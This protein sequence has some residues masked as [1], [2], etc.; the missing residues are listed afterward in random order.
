[1]WWREDGTLTVK[2]AGAALNGTIC[3]L[4]RVAEGAALRKGAAVSSICSKF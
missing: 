2:E 1:M 4:Q 3:S